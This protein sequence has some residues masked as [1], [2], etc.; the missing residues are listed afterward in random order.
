M[1][2]RTPPGPESD[3]ASAIGVEYL[4]DGPDPATAR[5]PVTDAVRQPYGIVHGGAYSTI[6]ESIASRSTWIA[7]RD[8]GMLAFGQSSNA[9][10]LRPIAE[11]T[12]HATARPIQRGRTTWV[13]DCE[14]SD[15]EGRLCAVVRMTIA[16]RPSR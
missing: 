13:W 16:V 2:E 9:T 1:N 5:V 4:D 6:A 11:G 7:V 15:D 8:E 14:I 12:I 3:L 10:F